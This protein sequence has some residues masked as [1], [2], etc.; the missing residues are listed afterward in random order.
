MCPGSYVGRL[1]Y[2]RFC[3]RALRIFPHERLAQRP[4]GRE[5][6]DNIGPRRQ[7]PQAVAESTL[8]VNPENS[9]VRYSPEGGL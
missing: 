4:D 9:V 6:L 2:E 8:K 3:G 1:T 5:D 7:P